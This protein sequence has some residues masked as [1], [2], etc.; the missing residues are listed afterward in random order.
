MLINAILEITSEPED[1]DIEEMLLEE[2]VRQPKPS[3]TFSFE[4]Y[5]SGMY[6]WGFNRVSV[7]GVELLWGDCRFIPADWGSQ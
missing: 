1:D 6:L 5:E 3:P 7:Q 2:E 4:E